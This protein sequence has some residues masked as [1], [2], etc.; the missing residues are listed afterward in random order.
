MKKLPTFL[1]RTTFLFVL[2][3][4][5]ATTTVSLAVWAVS[6]TAQ[7]ATLTASAAASAVAGRKAT[8]AAVAR[9]KAKARLRRLVVAVPVAGAAAA[10]WF[11][12]Q[13]Y[14]QWKEDNPDDDAAAY[15]CEVSA[16]SAEIIDEVLQELPA[17]ARPPRDL[18]LSQ[19][20]ECPSAET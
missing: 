5:L 18:L 15:G 12:R 6:L 11:E 10:I 17:K 3:V 13:D 8:A 16:T 19:L 4:S 1:R 20:P 9:T 14:L 7:V 2:C